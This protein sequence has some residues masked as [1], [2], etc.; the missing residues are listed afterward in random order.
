[1]TT[2]N[3]DA[4]AMT[5][6]GWSMAAQ[7]GAALAAAMGVGRFVF[8]PVLPL[9]EAQAHLLPAQASVLATTNY[10]GYLLG[11]ILG[12]VFPL[13]SR[14]RIASRVSGVV[15]IATL[16]AM[17]LTEN[18]ATWAAIRGVA[19]VASAVVF[20]VA[21]STILTELAS[22]RPHMV[23]WAYG[24]VG[25]GIAA[26]GILVA[27]VGSSSS[28]EASWWSAAA[29]TGLLLGVAWFIGEPIRRARSTTT[30]S[31]ASSHDGAGRHRKWFIAL[32]AS[33][34]FEGAGYIVAG[35]FLVAAVT[36]TGPVWL[37]HSV[38]TIVG[39][40]AIPSCAAWT[41]LSGRISRPTLITGALILQ[42]IGI[43]LPVLSPSAPAAVISALL[44][45][46]TFVGV[47]TLTLATGRHLL[48]PRAIAI[49]TAGYGIGQVIGPIIVAPTLGSGYRTAML[50]GAILVLAV[51][52]GAAILRVRFPH[53]DQP[54][55][56]NRRI[57]RAALVQA[58]KA[59]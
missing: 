11:A 58:E 24:G 38:W 17:P 22:S 51:G 28:W 32:T 26:S 13:L 21:G 16:V 10:L 40:A 14:A 12:I 37:S 39:L 2:T 3:T 15:L 46:A 6:T 5:R 47:T 56:G 8:T 18:I 52:I 30:V 33:Y 43:A 41:L 36:A 42:A 57:P 34:F 23:G 44:F 49:L 53:R 48:V 35:T 20:M 59:R 1:M 50:V 31:S 45:G 7:T 9:M 54:H 27:V 55:R 29:L 25:A 19:G 4:H